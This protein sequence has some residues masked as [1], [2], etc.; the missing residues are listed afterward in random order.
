MPRGARALDGQVPA[1]LYGG[2]EGA[3]A[4]SVNTKQLARFCARRPATTRSSR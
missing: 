4:L 1:V 3:M 2:K